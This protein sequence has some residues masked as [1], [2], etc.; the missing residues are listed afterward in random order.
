MRKT[1]K[2]ARSR[3][4][5]KAKL[6]NPPKKLLT[7]LKKCDKKCSAYK[8]YTKSHRDCL[9]KNCKKLVKVV[10]M[11]KT[12]KG[13]RRRRGGRRG[14]KRMRGGYGK[15][16]C[17]F[18]GAPWTPGNDSNYYKLNQNGI[19]VGGSEPFSGQ[20]SPSPQHGGHAGGFGALTDFVINPSRVATTALGNLRNMY[21]G[22][23]LYGSPLP[24]SQPKL[25]PYSPSKF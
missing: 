3:K 20:N 1:R 14:S 15:A 9:K 10:N 24:V 2:H 13:G 16:T 17:P 4:S 8:R 5:N 22:E 12:L 18:I 19:G 7:L 11:A 25:E 23:P 6:K 21:A